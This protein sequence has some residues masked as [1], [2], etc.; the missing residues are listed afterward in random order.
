MR[1]HE[2]HDRCAPDDADR[3]ARRI[4]Q[5]GAPGPPPYQPCRDPRARAGRA[6]VAGLAGQPAEGGRGGHGA[7]RR[8]PRRRPIDGAAVADPAHR[9]RGAAGHALHRRYAGE[10]GPPISG[11]A[12]HLADGRG[13]SG[14]V[15]A[16]ARV[17]AD[18]VRAVRAMGWL[19][20]C[21]RP[22]SQARCWTQW[23]PPA[24]VLLRFRP[25]TGSATRLRAT[26]PGWHL[27]FNPQAARDPVTRRPLS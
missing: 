12:L 17:A 5:P 24:L 23:R 13:Q 1:S 16:M 8:P 27:A 22:P 6:V 2:R 20:Q 25:D 19:R 21:V 4:V 11:S 9:D 14:A 7:A 3:P 18:P 15:S 10:T 26:N